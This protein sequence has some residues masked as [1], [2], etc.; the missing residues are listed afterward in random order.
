[1]L[2]IFFTFTFLLLFSSLLLSYPIFNFHFPA[3]LIVAFT[4]QV[5]TGLITW[6]PI[7][8]GLCSGKWSAVEVYENEDYDNDADEEDVVEDVQ[9]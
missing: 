3:S 2:I 7:S 8:L 6:S 5:G 9:D 4:F 1:M